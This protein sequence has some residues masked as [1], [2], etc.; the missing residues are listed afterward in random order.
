[1]VCTY[2]VIIV[3]SLI[4]A[5]ISSKTVYQEHSVRLTS[6]GIAKYV[7]KGWKQNFNGSLGESNRDVII[8]E[9]LIE[10]ES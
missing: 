6:I 3:G 8:F 2:F 4:I 5:R 1:M 10:I 9:E 7:R